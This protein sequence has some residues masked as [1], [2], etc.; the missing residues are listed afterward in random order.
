[1]HSCWRSLL[2]Y[3]CGAAS[4]HLFYNLC[5]ARRKATLAELNEKLRGI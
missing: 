4:A 5:V 2:D 1:M 3:N